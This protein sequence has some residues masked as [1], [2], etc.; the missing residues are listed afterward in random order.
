MSDHY[1]L[2]TA[3]PPPACPGMGEGLFSGTGWENTMRRTIRRRARHRVT[4]CR[5]TFARDRPACPGMG[6]GL[7]SGTGWEN[8]MRRTIRRRAR[9]RVT[10]CRA[11][12]QSV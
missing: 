12:R 8:T 1:H 3:R 7:F 9:H 6:E 5:E 11:F 2:T 4:I 10:I